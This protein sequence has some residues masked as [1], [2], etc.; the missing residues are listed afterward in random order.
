MMVS[1]NLFSKLDIFILA[2]FK[3]VNTNKNTSQ[4]Q[5]KVQYKSSTKTNSAYFWYS[6]IKF[7]T[8]WR[9]R[10]RIW[11]ISKNNWHSNSNWWSKGCWCN[12]SCKYANAKRSIECLWKSKIYWHLN[13]ARGPVV[14]SKDL[15]DALNND[16]I[17][18]ACIDVFD[19]EPPLDLNDPLLNCKNTLVTPH[20][21][22]A[23]KQSMSLCAEIVFENLRAWMEEGKSNI[24]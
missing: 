19:K 20:V 9:K 12:D 13:V 15:A 4:E 14:V 8:F 3:Q 1:I 7:K 5:E 17:A 6:I 10:S 21:A 11:R 16:V 22:F 2:P 23:T 18:G 24:L